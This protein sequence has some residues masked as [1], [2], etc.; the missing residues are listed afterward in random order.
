MK[1][2]QVGVAM[3]PDFSGVELSIGRTGELLSAKADLTSAELD[4]LIAALI[5][6]SS[7]MKAETAQTT[8]TGLSRVPP[9]FVNHS[10][11]VGYDVSGQ[12]VLSFELVSGCWVSFQ[13]PRNQVDALARSLRDCLRVEPPALERP[14]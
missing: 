5:S 2:P 14:Q 9:P 7:Q 11:R 10:W 12:A 13:L 8:G 4:M 6:C 3:K 1:K